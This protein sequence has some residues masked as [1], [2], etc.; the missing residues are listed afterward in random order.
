MKGDKTPLSVYYDGS[1]PS[2]VKDRQ[3]YETLAGR[4]GDQVQWVDITGQ[5]EMLRAR[6]IEPQAALQELHVEDGDGRV[7]RE[8]DAYILLMSRVL[9][10]KPLA[11]IL[12]LP[13]I[14]G[15]LSRLYRRWVRQRLAREGRLPETDR[16]NSG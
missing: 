6:G 4:H 15:L 10:L 12:G 11:W 13:G 2:C 3:W 7:Y 8:L 1:C 16:G 5:D 9:V 14:G